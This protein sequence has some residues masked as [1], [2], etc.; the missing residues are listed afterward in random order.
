MSADRRRLNRGI[1]QQDARSKRQLRDPQL[2]AV[3]GAVEV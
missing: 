2:N 1:I 3:N